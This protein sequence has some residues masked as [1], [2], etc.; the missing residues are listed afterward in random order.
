MFKKLM[1][2]FLCLLLIFSLTACSLSIKLP[3]N[4]NESDPPS[5]IEGS[6]DNTTTLPDINSTP[7]KPQGSGNNSSGIIVKPSPNT[8]SQ[9]NTVSSPVIEAPTP[10]DTHH[11]AL[12][13]ESYYQYSTLGANG[14]KVY[15]DI[16]AAIEA[17][18][19]VVHL[20]RYNIGYDEMW[21]IYQKVIAD[22]PQYFWVSK[23]IQYTHWNENG[24]E[25][26]VDLFL[27]YT[28]GETTDNLGENG[29]LSSVASRDKIS[30][31]I[32][33]VNQKIEE[34]LSTI[35]S[36]YTE[37]E[38]ERLIHD[39]VLSQISYDHSAVG[40]SLSRVN[41]SRVYDIYGALINK[42]AVCEGYSRLFQYLCY[43]VGL[44]ATF[45]NGRSD[46]QAHAW[47]AVR[48]DGDWYH[49]D[50][51]WDDG[52]T[53]GIPLY[54]YFNLTAEQISLSHIIENDRL[55]V[56]NATATELSFTN[57]FGMMLKNLV[58]TPL[59]YQKAIDYAVKFKS[60]YI[61]IMTNNK[62]ATHMYGGF[63]MAYVFNS[64]SDIQ[65]YIKEK[66][67]SLKFDESSTPYTDTCIF[68]KC[69]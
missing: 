20:S 23:F 62:T 59:N 58:S 56:P 19:N 16:C 29:Q 28:D 22:N 38:K 45:V 42:K 12:L 39:I 27:F 14:K 54:D 11:T 51:T 67:Y 30:S 63:L 7:A 13:K 68:L 44:N 33:A 17:T 3:V 65:R 26:I 32:N 4:Q 5:E 1:A 66:G 40:Q 35:P 64:N 48:L 36:S 69:K 37:V 49:I 41:Y 6:S 9:N 25:K 21:I 50:T 46:N 8:S 31:Q 2:A 57:T 61:H 60:P 34:I 24:N 47:N 55:S 43:Q 15:N 52:S 18:Q 53:N 10:P